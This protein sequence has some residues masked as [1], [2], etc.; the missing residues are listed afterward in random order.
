MVRATG[1]IGP[2]HMDTS[3]EAAVRAFA[4]KPDATVTGRAPG[5]P[6]YRALGYD[7]TGKGFDGEAPIL[8]RCRTVFFFDPRTGKLETFSTSSPQYSEGHGVR[9]GMKQADAEQLLHQR[10]RI[11]CTTALHVGGRNGSLTVVFAGGV[12]RGT[13]ISG[14]H[15]DAFVLHGHRRDAGVFDCL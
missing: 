8:E 3:D 1:Q 6:R 5:S 10:L 9:I 7:C 12:G 13:S 2:L 11:G 15:V 14:A 4:G